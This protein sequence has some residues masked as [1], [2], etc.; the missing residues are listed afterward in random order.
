VSDKTYMILCSLVLLL[1]LA[2]VNALTAPLPAETRGYSFFNNV[3][4]LYGED[5]YKACAVHTPTW[6]AYDKLADDFKSRG[7]PPPCP[8]IIWPEDDPPAGG[9][10][11]FPPGLKGAG[12]EN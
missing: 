1:A 8:V 7:E 6:E 10:R 9:M 11:N 2:V 3:M 12:N 4:V 5:W